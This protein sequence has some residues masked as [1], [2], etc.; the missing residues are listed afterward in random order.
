MIMQSKLG[1]LDPLLEKVTNVRQLS[2]TEKITVFKEC[3]TRAGDLINRLSEK[4]TQQYK[5]MWYVNL[6]RSFIGCTDLL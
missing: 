6:N 5:D 4:G 3:L 1:E 2:K